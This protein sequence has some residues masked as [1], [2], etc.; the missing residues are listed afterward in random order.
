MITCHSGGCPGADMAWETIGKELGIKTIAYSFSGHIHQGENPY[1]MNKDELLEGWNCILKAN[2]SLRKYPENQPSYVKMLLCRNWF[3][4]KNSNEI[5][6]VGKFL[7]S[8]KIL[9]SG[10]TGWAVQM[11]IDNCKP[12]WVYEMNERKW[13]TFD[14]NKKEFVECSR[15]KIQSNN[16]AGIG[17]RDLSDDGFN[18]IGLVLQESFGK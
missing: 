8:K 11:A 17:S 13:F 1:V 4:I 6:A 5:Y 15:P 14:Y 7:N 16:F 18:E 2:E 9:V 10:G 12:T 3:Q